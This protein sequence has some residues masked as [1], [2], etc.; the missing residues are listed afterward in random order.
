MQRR[1]P[2]CGSCRRSGSGAGALLRKTKTPAAAAATSD[3]RQARRAQLASGKCKVT[4]VV[5]A[6]AAQQRTRVVFAVEQLHEVIA[7]LLLVLHLEGQE[8]QSNSPAVGCF[9]RPLALLPLLVV[10]VAEL[11]VRV[12]VG[13][14]CVGQQSSA[15]NCERMCGVTQRKSNKRRANLSCV[16]P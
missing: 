16:L 2:C 1:S 12:E 11:D 15:A 3:R 14:F 9:D 6:E 5:A 4:H 7:A 13:H 10:V 8:Q